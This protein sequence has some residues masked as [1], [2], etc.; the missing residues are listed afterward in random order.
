MLFFL[1]KL[2]PLATLMTKCLVIIFFFVLALTY[3]LCYSSLFF[4]QMLALSPCG[5]AL[6]D[7]VEGFPEIRGHRY[8]SEDQAETDIN[9]ADTL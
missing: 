6:I 2:F 5:C 7:V 1:I 4:F 3:N 9:K 8:W